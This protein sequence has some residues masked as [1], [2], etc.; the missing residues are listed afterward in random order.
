MSETEPPKQRHLRAVP[1]SPAPQPDGQT[2]GESVVDIATAARNRMQAEIRRLKA[3]NDALISLAKA[4]LA[5]QAQTHAAVLALLE[6]ETLAALDRKLAGRVAGALN[7][8]LI[9]IFIEGHAPMRTAE[10]VLGAAPDLVRAL[11]GDS[12]ERLGPVDRRFAD[13]LYGPQAGRQQSEAMVRLDIAGR[14]GVLCLA[15]RDHDAFT[16]EQGSDL[17]HFLARVIERRLAMF[18]RDG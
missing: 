18:L 11:L 12:G 10:C 5:V 9:R 1:S 15:A 14:T 8:D 13:A 3:T 17:L 6:A 16:P 7:V 4:N 2:R